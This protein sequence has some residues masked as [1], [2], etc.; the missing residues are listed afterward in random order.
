MT[1]ML[2]GLLYRVSRFDPATFAVTSALLVAVAVIACGMPA[3]RATA[4]D[5]RRALRYEYANGT[6]R[7]Q[8][9]SSMHYTLTLACGFL[10]AA[11]A[12]PRTVAVSAAIDRTQ[13]TRES[14]LGSY[15]VTEHYTIR[16]LRFGTAAELV[17]NVTYTREA[18]K[19]YSV[20]S[21][22]GSGM[23]QTRVLDRLLSEEA[24][25]SHG[26]TRKK[27]LV[28]TANYA[29]RSAGEEVIE[30]R[31]CDVVE[32]T[33]R[34]KSTHL[35]KGWLWVEA[36]THN[37]VRI[38]GTPSESPSFFAGA[39]KITREYADIEGLA[40]AQHSVAISGSL[41]AGKTELTIEYSD[42]KVH[43]DGQ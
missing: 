37:I 41:L 21:R 42:Y 10:M 43:V 28:T 2:E 31:H 19:I 6:R 26:D 17:A 4:V 11:A 30:G 36:E 16:N 29:M 14:R 12:D 8:C 1:R 27:A 22:S 15:S 39:P 25:M 9:N 40:F 38:E 5:P 13:I 18:G 20:V 23:L 35:V 33:P 32:L 3:R 34:V 7:A 24:A